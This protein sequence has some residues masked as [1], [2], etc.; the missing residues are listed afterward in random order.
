MLARAAARAAGRAPGRTP[1]AA[2]DRRERLMPSP[3]PAVLVAAAH[4]ALRLRVADAFLQD[5]HDVAAADSLAAAQLGLRKHSSDLLIVAELDA[6]AAAYSLIETARAEHPATAIVAIARG[7]AELDRI[8]P[9]SRG[10]DAVAPSECSH[11]ELRAHVD[12]VLRRSRNRLSRI[13]SV[14][15]LEVEPRSRRVTSRGQ[16]VKLS[17]KEYALLVALVREPER[18]FTKAEL[19]RD[20]WGF[21]SHGCTRTLDSHACRLR[22]KLEQP[23]A[24]SFVQNVWGVGYRL[25]DPA[26]VVAAA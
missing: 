10:A 19:L 26:A 21:A 18:V 16:D 15:G 3:T 2:S 24:P 1:G 6:P 12:A 17:A 14:G 22:R 4:P 23:G 25:I 11:T 13:L 5:G 7:P 9:L 8:R 20:V